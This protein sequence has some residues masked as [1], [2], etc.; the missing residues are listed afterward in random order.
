MEYT[1]RI[2]ALAERARADRA[3]F[4]LPAD[5]PDREQALGYLREGVGQAVGVYIEAR[6]GPDAPVRFETAAYRRL[7]RA[8]NDWLV[9]YAACHGTRIEASFTLR[10]AAELLVDT[11]DI[12]AVARLLTGVPERR[13]RGSD[14]AV[15]SSDGGRNGN[16]S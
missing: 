13:E 12:A 1:A 15:A 5:P 11:H 8:M 10:T 4:E 9:L 3:A 6:A 14:P 2:D 7:E 16:K